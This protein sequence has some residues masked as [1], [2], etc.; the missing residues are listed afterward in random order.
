MLKA[1]LVFVEVVSNVDGIGMILCGLYE[2]LVSPH[3]RQ[4]KG[5]KR[6]AYGPIGYIALVEMAKKKGGRLIL[7]DCDLSPRR[8]TLIY[9]SLS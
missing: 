3:R 7:K 8:N 9:A 1:G 2:L 5:R 4:K 6:D